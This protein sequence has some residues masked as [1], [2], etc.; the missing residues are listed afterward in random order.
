M[1]Y[2]EMWWEL[3]YRVEDAIEGKDETATKQHIEPNNNTLKWVMQN[4]KELE[5]EY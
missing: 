3:K 1:S 4:I 5:E 2:K